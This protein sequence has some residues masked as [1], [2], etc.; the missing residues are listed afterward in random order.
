MTTLKKKQHYVWRRYLRSWTNKGKIYCYRQTE[1]KL[2]GSGT[3]SIANEMFFYALEQLSE[4]DLNYIETLIARATSPGL[5]ELH[6]GTVNMFQSI[7]VLEN[8]LRS[9]NFTNEQRITLNNELKRTKKHL[10]R[11]IIHEWKQIVW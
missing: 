6:Q 5:R 3:D 8:Q 9:M 7:F 11:T 10:Q 4:V 1:R 2:F